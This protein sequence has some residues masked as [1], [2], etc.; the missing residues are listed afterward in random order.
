MLVLALGS[1]YNLTK[2]IL[3]GIMQI[4][5]FTRCVSKSFYTVRWPFAPTKRKGLTMSFKT[6]L[7]MLGAAAIGT[8]L[9]VIVGAV[10]FLFVSIKVGVTVGIIGLALCGALSVGAV[11]AWVWCSFRAVKDPADTLGLSDSERREF[12]KMRDF[13][14]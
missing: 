2:T 3:F 6:M 12:A 9:A 4:S 13:R 5:L 1:Y 10:L 8:F 14:I 11:V 7:K